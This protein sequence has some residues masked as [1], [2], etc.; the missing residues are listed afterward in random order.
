MDAPMAWCGE[1]AGPVARRRVALFFETNPDRRHDDRPDQ[2]RVGDFLGWCCGAGLGKLFL[3][4]HFVTV[5][6][7]GN[8]M[9]VTA[10]TVQM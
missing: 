1:R 8:A 9:E 4:S 2:I 10:V 3:K 7:A 6:S 5:T